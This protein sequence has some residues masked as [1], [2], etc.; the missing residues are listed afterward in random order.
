MMRLHLRGLAL[1]FAECCTSQPKH[2]I[3]NCSSTSSCT[4]RQTATRPRHASQQHSVSQEP[5][6]FARQLFVRGRVLLSLHLVAV[7]S[8]AIHGTFCVFVD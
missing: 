2:A 7:Y 5:E 4:C 6:R 3:A 1:V 8:E